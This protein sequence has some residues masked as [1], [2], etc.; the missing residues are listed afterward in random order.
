MHIISRLRAMGQR[1]ASKARHLAKCESGLALIE[2]AYCLPVFTGLGLTGVEIANLAIANMKVSQIAMAVA[3]NI[4]RSKQAVPLGL[5][6]L[7]EHDINDAF[8]GANLQGENLDVFRNGR[9]IIS[10]L[11]QNASGGQWI[12]WQ[13]CKGMRSVV[14]SYGAEGTGA[15]GTA[16]PGMGTASRRVVAE[17]GTAVIFVEFTYTYKSLVASTILGPITLREETAFFVR[18]DRDLTRVYNPSPTVTSSACNVFTAT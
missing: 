14:S 4:S 13:R 8:I 6:Q 18:D 17:P 12:A 3:D 15:T 10:S 16:F 11:Q 9:I 5:P 1:A 2:F 7:R